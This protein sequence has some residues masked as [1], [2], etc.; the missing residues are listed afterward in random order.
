MPVITD[1]VATE[2]GR[3]T[4]TG[5]VA[6]QWQSWIGQATYLIRKHYGARYSSLA[7]EDV[8]YVVLQAVVAHVR[9][10]DDAIQVDVAG[11]DGRVSRRYTSGYGSVRI[12]D[13]W[14]ALLDASTT[15]TGGA[16]TVRPSGAADPAGSD[17]VPDWRPAWQ[18]M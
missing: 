15:T 18:S 16:F 6:A 13:E 2:L 11:D 8:D 3:P 10:P 12:R 4:P 17:S 5:V 9:R 14:W 1:D 7:A